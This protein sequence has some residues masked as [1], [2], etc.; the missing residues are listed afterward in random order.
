MLRYSWAGAQGVGSIDRSQ[1]SHGGKLGERS[2]RR[3]CRSSGDPAKLLQAVEE[4]FD[5]V[6]LAVERLRPP[7]VLG[8]TVGSVRDVGNYTLATDMGSDAV[9]VITF[10][11]SYHGASASLR[12]ARLGGRPDGSSRRR[13]WIMW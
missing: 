11:A 4:A 6:A 7:V 1:I 8:F 12:P 9:G 2:W 5:T 13:A 10:V 3:A